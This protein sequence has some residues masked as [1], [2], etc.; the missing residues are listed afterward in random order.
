MTESNSSSLQE[1]QSRGAL[2][3]AHRVL[4]KVGTSI[5]ANEDGRPSLVRLGSIVEQISELV[6]Y[7]KQVIFVSSGDVVMGKRLLRKQMRKSMSFNDLHHADVDSKNTSNTTSNMVYANSLLET[8]K[9]AQLNKNHLACAAAGQFELMN[10]YS[11]LFN[12]CE[13]SASQILVTQEDFRDKVHLENLSFAIER[14]LSLG[15][16][17][18]INENG[19]VSANTSFSDND[20][21]A[22]ICARNFRVDVILLLT[23]VDGVYTHPP[24][25]MEAK[26]LKFYKTNANIILGGNKSDKNKTNQIQGGMGP[27]IDAAINAVKPG[28]LCTACVV[29]SGKDLNSIRAIL[30]PS[31]DS[32][33]GP[34]KGT[35]FATPGT[36]LWDQ[37]IRDINDE[38]SICSNVNSNYTETRKMAISA[39]NEARKLMVLPYS[40]RQTILHTI[41]DC[42]LSNKDFILKANISDLNAAVT[43]KASES[44]IKRLKLSYQE[45]STLAV[46]I[47]HIARQ[48]D[49]LGV[50][51]SKQELSNG[52]ELSQITVPIGVIMFLFESRPDSLPQISALSLASGNG[53]LLKGVKEASQSNAALLRVIGDAIETGSQG[54]ISREIISLVISREQVMDMLNND[55]VIDLIIPRCGNQLVTH[56]K[57]NTRIPVLGHDDGVCHVYI[58]PT[59]SVDAAIKIAVDAKTDYPTA[60]NAM[61]TLLLHVDTLKN[62]VAMKTLMNLR[63]AGV[64]CL[65]GPGAMKAGLCDVAAVEMKCVYGNLTC[66][67]EVVQSIDEAIDW[68][69]QYGS[70]HTEVIVCGENDPNGEYFLKFVDSACVFKN[71]ST[72]FSDGYCFGLGAGEFASMFIFSFLLL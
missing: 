1:P 28:S 4:I 55:D 24:N 62:G 30:G 5:V 11:N 42:L 59:A 60:S 21:L 37:C 47:R 23:D 70:G 41:A 32:K 36:D 29:A 52:L 67:V 56:L 17:P 57:T 38:N 6:R 65:G 8:S 49:P 35:L 31:Y 12:Q 19:T 25:L 50:L 20:S 63:S 22:A 34:P 13:I 40:E 14:L 66:M 2:R 64:K 61:E 7:G 44:L 51:K 69:H 72:R 48:S 26:M 53:L 45:L 9:A 27:K 18:I 15:V 46:D 10:L 39:R 43:T 3:S 33:Y 68:I 54:K 71:A 16:V 58:A